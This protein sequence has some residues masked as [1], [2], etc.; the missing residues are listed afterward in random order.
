V[1]EQREKT[2]LNLLLGDEHDYPWSIDE[3]VQMIGDRIDT[4][5]AV[6]RLEA[7]GLMHRLGEFVFPTL[8]ARSAD[9]LAEGAI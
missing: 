8:A 9:G 2:V 1:R 6:C 5:D 7:A 4:I 3:L